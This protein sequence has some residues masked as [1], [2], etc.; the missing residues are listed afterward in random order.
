MERNKEFEKRLKTFPDPQVARPDLSTQISYEEQ[1]QDVH[2]WVL[3]TM[4]DWEHD[5]LSQPRGWENTLE[6]RKDI[7]LFRETRRV[8]WNLYEVLVNKVA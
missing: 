7:S 3:K 8:F 4:R 6:G 5:N 2:R 1:C